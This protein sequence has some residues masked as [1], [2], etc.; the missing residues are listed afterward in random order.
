MEIKVF[1]AMIK[2][3]YTGEINDLEAEE[4]VDLLFCCVMYESWECYSASVQYLTK[5]CQVNSCLNVVERLYPMIDSSENESEYDEVTVD[6]SLKNEYSRRRDYRDIVEANLRFIDFNF[7][8]VICHGDQFLQLPF[9]LLHMILSRSGLSASSKE[10]VSSILRWINHDF[11]NREQHAF[12][13]LCL[14]KLESYDTKLL[15]KLMYG[16]SS[17]GGQSWLLKHHDVV[18]CVNNILIQRIE[19]LQ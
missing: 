17:V 12:D 15:Y 1:E 3:F 11:E 4:L 19:K 8:V 10:L 5:N 9:N 6:E 18:S 13:L 2:S 7:S 16:H 14:A